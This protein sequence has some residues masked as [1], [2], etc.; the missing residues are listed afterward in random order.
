MP[1]KTILLTL[2]VP[3]SFKKR[4]DRKV[5][6][7][8]YGTMANYIRSLVRRSFESESDGPGNINSCNAISMITWDK[9]RENLRFGMVNEPYARMHGYKVEELVGKPIDI[10]YAPSARKSLKNH[11][12]SIIR[13][14][15]HYAF[16]TEHMK[17][18]GTHFKVVVDVSPVA[19]DKGEFMVC[20]ATVSPMEAGGAGKR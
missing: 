7:G 4:I 17:K 20:L 5:K 13:R 15:S 10:V 8:G 18:D 19:D 9:N 11:V 12:N 3:L 14:E 1:D 2:K 6:E 16:A